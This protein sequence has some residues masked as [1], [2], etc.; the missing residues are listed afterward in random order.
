M[1]IRHIVRPGD[2]MD[3]ICFRYG[4]SPQRVWSDPANAPLRKLRRNMNI[5]QEGDV[6]I[7]PD[8]HL[9]TRSVATGQMH[10]FYRNEVPAVLRLKLLQDFEPRAHEDYV[11]T[12]NGSSRSGKTDANGMLVAYVPP[13]TIEVDLQI[14]ED[15]PITM[16]IGLLKPDDS[17]SGIQQRLNNLG[18]NCGVPSGE[19]TPQTKEALGSFQQAFNLDVTGKPDEQT[20]EKLMRVHDSPDL[21]EEHRGTP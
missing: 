5:L 15:E 18:F 4:F 19:M 1:P 14:G 6:V 12:V 11:L 16:Q 7:V 21:L 20:V 13:N 9:K 2:T 17:L 10:T 8:K 3:N